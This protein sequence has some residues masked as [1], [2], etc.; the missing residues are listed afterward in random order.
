MRKK[1]L[2][3]LLL[4]SLIALAGCGKKKLA[5]PPV[6]VAPSDLRAEVISTSEIKLTWQVNSMTEEGFFVYRK[7]TD[8]YARVATMEAKA[9][10]YNDTGLSPETTY[11]YKVNAYN[12]EGESASSNEV[13]VITSAEPLSPLEPPTNLTATVVSYKQINLSWR[14]NSTTEDGFIVY[15][16]IG[17][18]QTKT[19]ATLSPNTTNMN[20]VNYNQ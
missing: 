6:P 18:T 8:N 1:Y 4:A 16:N 12:D 9:W 2:V 13:S 17:H 10:S 11:W 15:C 7:T 14:D 5:P 3:L 19:I 20:I